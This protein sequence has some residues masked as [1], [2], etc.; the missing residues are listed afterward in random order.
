MSVD[1]IAR[2]AEVVQGLDP[3]Q[4]GSMQ[5]SQMLYHNSWFTRRVLGAHVVEGE[6]IHLAIDLPVAP[7]S[8]Q[9]MFLATMT[10]IGYLAER[11]PHL[12][13]YAPA[14]IGVL[15]TRTAAGSVPARALITE[16]I[17]KGGYYPLVARSAPASLRQRL[18]VASLGVMA[19]G[20]RDLMVGVAGN[21]RK[22]IQFVPK[23]FNIDFSPADPLTAEVQR[24]QTALTLAISGNSA[25]GARFGS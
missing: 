5:P 22:I 6:L 4:I 10:Q 3:E 8:V 17:T 11:A 18:A 16:D 20:P 9:S 19:E 25:L 21:Q 14:F 13:N 24:A 2:S 23:P 1:Y 15:G 12:M 7:A